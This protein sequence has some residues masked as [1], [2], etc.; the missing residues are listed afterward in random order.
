MVSP[1]LTM[2]AWRMVAMVK[3]VESTSNPSLS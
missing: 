1:L 2:L 3:P